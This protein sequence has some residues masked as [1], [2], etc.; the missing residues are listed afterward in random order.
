MRHTFFP[1]SMAALVVGV[2]TIAIAADSP[3]VKY[4]EVSGARTTL[5]FSTAKQG[6]SADFVAEARKYFENFHYQM[7]GDHALYYNLRLSEFLP[8]AIRTHDDKGMQ[9]GNSA[10]RQRRPISE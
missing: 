10:Y 2:G 7:G 3:L 8:T 6:F 1:L 9:M 5:L 4:L